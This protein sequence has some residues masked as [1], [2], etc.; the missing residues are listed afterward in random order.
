M[1]DPRE[2]D[3]KPPPEVVALVARDVIAKRAEILQ[4]ELLFGLPLAF[5]FPKGK[6]NAS[7]SMAYARIYLV[8]LEE[9]FDHQYSIV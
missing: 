2:W 7:S 6:V 1:P 5:L 9:R 8:S 4:E 3:K